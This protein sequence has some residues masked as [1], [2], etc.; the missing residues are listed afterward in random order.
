MFYE[1]RCSI[2]KTIFEKETSSKDEQGL[3]EQ[4]C[5]FCGGKALRKFTVPHFGDIGNTGATK[6]G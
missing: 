1:Y 4:K 3:K 5:P 6:G 2:C